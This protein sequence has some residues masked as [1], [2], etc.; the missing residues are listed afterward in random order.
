MARKT[1][2][3]VMICTVHRGVFFGYLEQER[4]SGKTVDISAARCAIQ[5]GTT[6]GVFELAGTGP[7]SRS[8]IGCRAPLVTLYDVTAVIHCTPVAT[9][10]WEAA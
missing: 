1:K 6:A 5:F 10:A 4:D 9:K 3:P 7:T 8:K 2:K